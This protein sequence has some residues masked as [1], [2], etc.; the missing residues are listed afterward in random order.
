MNTLIIDLINLY[1]NKI[2]TDLYISKDYQRAYYVFNKRVYYTSISLYGYKIIFLYKPSIDNGNACTCLSS[3]QIERR[4]YFK[5]INEET[6][7]EAQDSA[8]YFMD[9]FDE[10]PILYPLS[11][12]YNNKNGKDFKYVANN[13]IKI[14]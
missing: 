2:I 14:V 3:Y 12:L 8:F 4:E 13:Y 1:N 7:E 5:E 9:T 11:D 6:L 10:Y